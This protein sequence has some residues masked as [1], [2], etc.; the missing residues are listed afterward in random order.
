MKI[1]FILPYFGKFDRLFPL[2]LESCR[3]N[4]DVDW[5]VFTDDK[6]PQGYPINV[7]VNYMRFE[8]LREIFQ[9]RFDFPIS[10]NSPYRLCNFKPAYGELFADY[11]DGFDAWGFCDNDMIYGNICKFLPASHSDK[12]KFGRYG[13]LTMIPNTAEG[14]T[15]Y[16]YAGAYKI[17]FSTP[18]PLYF[19]EDSFTKIL[20]K[21]DYSE[22]PLHIA[23]FMPRIK[24]FEV[25][26]EPGC[27]WKNKAHCFVWHDGILK[28]YYIS[29]ND[30]IEQEEYAYIH[31]LKRPMEVAEGIDT[32]KP[33]VII[34][35]K[36]F[37]MDPEEITKEFLLEVSKKGVFYAYW[38]NSLR[39]KNLLERLRNRLWQNK[40]NS[41][42]ITSMNKSIMDYED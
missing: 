8:D 31:F 28:R 16:R 27:E 21:N 38:K 23:D 36:I 35:N 24:N 19:D 42:I 41:S 20:L 6:T 32:D 14:R 33:L 11:L 26:N 25:L 30:T 29:K 5:F 18:Q 4:P 3:N 37:N 40:L 15:I 22:Y 7:H 2:W 12:F 10:L 13:H 17:A 39:P 9:S 1:A 34:P